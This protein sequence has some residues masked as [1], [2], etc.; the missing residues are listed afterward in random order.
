MACLSPGFPAYA[1][2]HQKIDSLKQVLAEH[3]GDSSEVKVLLNLSWH[4]AYS[5][6]DSGLY[7]SREA[8]KLSQAI[9]FAKGIGHALHGIGFNYYRKGQ[10]DSATVYYEKSLAAKQEIRDSLGISLTL[11]NLGNVHKYKG[12]Y[13]RALA[14]YQ[15]ALTMKF[16]LGDS[17][18]AATTITNIGAIYTIQEKYQ[19]ALENYHL[20]LKI[21]RTYGGR[22]APISIGT[23]LNHI[24]VVYMYLEDFPQAINY[25][26]ESIETFDSLYNKCRAVEPMINIGQCYFQMGKL[27]LSLTYLRPAYAQS[28]ECNV[29]DTTIPCLLSLGRIYRKKG[30]L[31]QSETSFLEAY[32]LANEYDL[33]PNMEES[34]LVLY[35]LYKEKGHFRKALDFLE[36]NTK[37][38]DE[39]SNEDLTKQ[40]TTM[41]LNY[42]F[43]QERD[44]LEYQ[45]QAELLTVNSKLERQRIVQ[46]VVVIGL[47]IALI[48]ALVI[49]RYYRLGQKAKVILEKK[50]QTISESLNEREVLLQEIHHRVKNNL[51]VV[52]SLL[53][54]QSKYLNDELAKKAVLEGRNRVQS[55]ALVHQ[56]LYQSESLSQL[57]VHEYLE[58][59]AQSLF[60][61]YDISEDRIQLSSQIEPV[62]LSLDTTIQIG[63]IINELVSN[64]LKHAFPHEQGGTISLSLRKQDD[65]YE[66]EVSDNGVGIS[67]ESDLQKSYGYRIVKSIC[68]G[69]NG[70]ISLHHLQGTSFKLSFAA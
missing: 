37:I 62:N 64:A 46:Y 9:E 38:K 40:L 11:N 17:S 8:L 29:S 34:A 55:M 39:L 52:S 43:E 33:K 25:F 13:A 15:Q 48:F 12:E 60:Q 65:L 14:Y 31:S 59:L 21:N 54:V 69:L 63:L 18:F 57:D 42:T 1:Q 7:Y 41:E 5:S 68:R 2:S 26:E 32:R 23:T 44:S 49:Y 53:N 10:W 16:A 20:T 61:S 27:D 45:K 30:L 36:I 70:T 50:N 66:L 24:G 58:E 56:K 35:Q 67:S 19:Q 51:Q 28:K 22:T 3:S 47:I 6:Y 4:Y